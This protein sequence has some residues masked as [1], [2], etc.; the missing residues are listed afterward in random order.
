MNGLSD[1]QQWHKHLRTL[2]RI[3]SQ[4]QPD[5]QWHLCTKT[6]P[7]ASGETTTTSSNKNKKQNKKQP[8]PQQQQQRLTASCV[9]TPALLCLSPLQMNNNQ[10]LSTANK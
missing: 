10:K 1:T 2:A 4:Q 5:Q 8:Q 9:L 6:A 7:T 3:V